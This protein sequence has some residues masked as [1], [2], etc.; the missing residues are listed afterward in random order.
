ML[1]CAKANNDTELASL[2]SDAQGVGGDGQVSL[3]PGIVDFF[4][5]IVLTKSITII[6]AGLGLDACILDGHEETRHFRSSPGGITLAF[7]G[8][9]FFNG[10]ADDSSTSGLFGGSLRL[11]GSTNIIDG[12]L[13]YN[14]RAI[15]SSGNAVSIL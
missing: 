10:L 1:G 8:L 11:I 14:N 13:F 12:S 7:I 2:I 4:N 3:C 5:E 15:S 6:C 9:V